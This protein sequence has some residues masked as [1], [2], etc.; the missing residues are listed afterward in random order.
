MIPVVEVLYHRNGI[1]IVS[2]ALSLLNVAA[3]METVKTISSYLRRVLNILFSCASEIIC[4][5]I[6]LKHLVTKDF[7]Q[8]NLV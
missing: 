3:F 5:S 7:R 4:T 2:D 6:Y 8:S 1:F